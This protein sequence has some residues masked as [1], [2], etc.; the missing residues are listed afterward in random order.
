MG[1]IINNLPVMN[2][3]AI[4]NQCYVNIRNLKNTKNDNGSFSLECNVNYI[5]INTNMIFLV[6]IYQEQ[7]QTPFSGELWSYLYNAIKN[8]FTSQGLTWTDDIKTN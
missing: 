3:N 1:L 5:N 2:G 6:D 4:V 8:K 7:I